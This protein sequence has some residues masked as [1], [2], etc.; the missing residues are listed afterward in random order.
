MRQGNE[1]LGWGVGTCTWPAHQRGAE[2]RVRLM[3]DGTARVS[4]ATQD[5]GTGTYTIFAQIIADRTGVPLDKIDVVLGDSSLPPGPTSGG[6]SATSTVIPAIAKATDNAVQAVLKAAT[7]TPPA[8]FGN[9]GPR[10]LKM[11]QG[12]VHAQDQPPASGIPFQEILISQKLAGLDGYAKTDTTD[13][14]KN[15][16]THSFG[17]HF[18][19]VAFDETSCACA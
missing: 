6:S 15:Y 17:V 8:A 12:R 13:E 3:A 19:E 1:I 4:C 7:R 11:G 2:V 14:Q 18:C 9:V 10:G 16:S 5:I